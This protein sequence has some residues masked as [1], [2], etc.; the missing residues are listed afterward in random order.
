MIDFRAPTLINSEK[1]PRRNKGDL[2]V[3][4]DLG[5][6]ENRGNDNNVANVGDIKDESNIGNQSNVEVENKVEGDG[7][8]SNYK[9]DSQDILES[10]SSGEDNVVS[11]MSGFMKGKQF[12]Y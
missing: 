9:S 12:R 4:A 7:Y 11:R 5:I 1:E 8:L 10:G 3:D 2:G 6:G